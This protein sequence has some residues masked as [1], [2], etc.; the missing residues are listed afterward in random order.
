[1]GWLLLA[2]G[3]SLSAAGPATAY[4]NDG[5]AQ[6]DAP[7]AGVVALYAPALIVVAM[8]CSGF[9][10]LLTPT[11]TL[12][13]PRW[14]WWAGVTAAT[15]VLLLLVVTLLSRPGDR[16]AQALESPLDLHAFDGGLL[17]AY[18]TAFAVA[19]GA[20][21]VAAASLVVRFRRAR[22]VERQQLARLRQQV[23][24]DTLTA[25][26]LSVV[27]QTVQPTQ[28]SLWLRPPA[29]KQSA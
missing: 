16:R 21:V 22:G 26:L 11:G 18:R 28:A 15:P 24:L 7:A 3:L 13:S 9:I 10:L 1:V 27:D 25:E 5:T 23:D 19:V 20:V 2:F 12:P 17:T 6:A 4:T 14:R 8:A 29:A